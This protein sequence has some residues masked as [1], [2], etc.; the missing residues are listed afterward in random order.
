[1]TTYTVGAPTLVLR[2]SKGSP[3]LNSEVDANFT[4]LSNGLQTALL[5]STY[6]AA[7]VLAKLN[8]VTGYGAASG[9]NAD[10]LTWNGGARSA[11]SANTANTIIA[12]DGN[13][14]FTATTI[15]ATTFNGTFSGTAAIT[16]G[17]ITLGTPL[18][19]T[20]GGTGAISASAARTNLGLAI[21][22]NVEAWSANLDALSGVTS[23]ADTAPYFTGSGT[24]STYSF[25]SYMRGVAGSA[26]SP[27]A[28]SNLGLTIGTNVQAYSSNL[29][30]L[31]ST[32]TGIQVITGSGT[33]A[34]RSLSAGTGITISNADGTAGNPTISVT[35]YVSSVQGQTG[36]VT[37]SVPVTSVQGQTGAV[38]VS[39]V[40][41]ASSAGYASNSG[42]GWPTYL[43]QFSNN[44]GNYGAWTP[45]GNRH[46]QTNCVNF[47][48]LAGSNNC[49]NINCNCNMHIHQDTGSAMDPYH[50]NNNC[51]NCNCNCNC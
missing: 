19:I 15:N 28:R 43:S 33:A 35:S 36:A 12:R 6:T 31:S 47:G 34:G 16:G 50:T 3:L 24:A 20:S 45:H 46:G 5:A 1:M 29:A 37:V 26:D 22:T 9:L 23:A 7:D 41:Y 10:T 18:A 38:T 32:G 30:A 17:T 4:N 14:A 11:S 40:G 13:G 2:A 44:L 21:G 25:T 39:S 27:T 48:R 49:G 51:H 8:T 42:S